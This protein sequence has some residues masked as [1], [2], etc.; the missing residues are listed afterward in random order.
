MRYSWRPQDGRE[1]VDAT[2]AALWKARER[3]RW[4]ALLVACETGLAALEVSQTFQWRRLLGR[5]RRD[6]ERLAAAL[7]GS[8]RARL[9]LWWL[10]LR[11]HGAGGLGALRA[12][13]GGD[14]RTCSD[15]EAALQ[16]RQQSE[17]AALGAAHEE[18][19][20]RLAERAGRAYAAAM[21]GLAER[22]RHDAEAL[23]PGAPEDVD[24]GVEGAVVEGFLE[25]GSGD[26][27]A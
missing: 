5:Q 17:A 21:R 19:I 26:A 7:G 22:C 9:A 27:A 23:L 20:R 14:P 12:A 18:R 11:P 15:W 1:G 10:R 8:L 3:V 16:L 6:R 25:T 2:A 13:A 24:A 4:D